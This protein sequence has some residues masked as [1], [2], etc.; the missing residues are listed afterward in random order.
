[1][2][3]STPE[4]IL[5]H[6]LRNLAFYYGGDVDNGPSDAWIEDLKKLYHYLLT[7]EGQPEWHQKIYGNVSAE[8]GDGERLH[9]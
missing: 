3:Q 5:T 7:G 8:E 1:M 4:E 9:S 2:K 6:T